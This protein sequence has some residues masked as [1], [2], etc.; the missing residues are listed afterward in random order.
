MGDRGK[1]RKKVESREI[2]AAGWIIILTF[3]IG[4][5][6]VFFEYGEY[7]QYRDVALFLYIFLEFLP[8]LSYLASVTLP[9]LSPHLLLPWICINVLLLLISSILVL[10]LSI[11]RPTLTNVLLSLF[12]SVFIIFPVSFIISMYLPIVVYLKKLVPNYK[13]KIRR[14]KLYRV[15]FRTKTAEEIENEIIWRRKVT[16]S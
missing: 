12:I 3:L 8:M 16:H 7:H 1:S 13:K 5:P 15:I 4:L 6:V 11:S 14:S 10:S 9:H 2:L